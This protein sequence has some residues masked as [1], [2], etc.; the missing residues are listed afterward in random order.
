M[1]SNGLL[2]IKLENKN[3]KYLNETLNKIKF[4]GEYFR[5]GY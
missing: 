4:V 5:D 1:F 3:I 2:K